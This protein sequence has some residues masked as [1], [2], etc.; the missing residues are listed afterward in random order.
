MYF[1]KGCVS[2][3]TVGDPGAAL[4]EHMTFHGV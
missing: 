4:K 1:V 2:Y 3:K